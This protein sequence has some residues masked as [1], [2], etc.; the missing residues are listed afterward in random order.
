M[1]PK[2]DASPCRRSCSFAAMAAAC[3]PSA[4]QE[5]L[6]GIPSTCFWK[7]AP[8]PG[9]RSPPL[10]VIPR[11]DDGIPPA[12]RTGPWFYDVWGNPLRTRGNGDALSLEE[13]LDLEFVEEPGGGTGIGPCER[14]RGREGLGSGCRDKEIDGVAPCH[15][16]NPVGQLLQGRR[17]SPGPPCTMRDPGHRSGQPRTR[18]TLPSM[19]TGPRAGWRTR[20]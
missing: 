16:K 1:K 2:G 18:R 10:Q 19:P 14:D 6:A 7:T 8:V 17:T 5:T 3:F 20:R 4:I 12:T 9:S 13:L 15:L 11:P